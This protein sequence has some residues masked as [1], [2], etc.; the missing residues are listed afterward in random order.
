MQCCANLPSFKKKGYQK[1]HFFG[2]LNTCFHGDVLQ[3]IMV[4][5]VGACPISAHLGTIYPMSNCVQQLVPILAMFVGLL[6]RRMHAIT[7]SCL[8]DH[9]SLIMPSYTVMFF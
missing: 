5:E 3:V 7:Q 6:H 4:A 1:K 2:I 8:I 9:A